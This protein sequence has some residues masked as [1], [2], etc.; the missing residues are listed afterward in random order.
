MKNILN[1]ITGHFTRHKE[2]TFIVK[3]VIVIAIILWVKEYMLFSLLFLFFIIMPFF[4]LSWAIAWSIY[5]GEGVFEIIRRNI[6]ILPGIFSDE[7]TIGKK[8]PWVTYALVIINIAVYYLI[9]QSSL[10]SDK[11]ISNNF[12]FAPREPNLWNAPLSLFTYMFLHGS[13]GHLWGNMF[14]LWG[15]GT[16]LEKR[17]DHLKFFIVYIITGLMSGIVMLFMHYTFLDRIS[18]R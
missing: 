5:T 3:A 14:F 16:E 15:V 2:H 12:I 8:L 9:Q 4:F 18:Q 7:R 17:M 11:T 6:T 10:L 13:P 1:R